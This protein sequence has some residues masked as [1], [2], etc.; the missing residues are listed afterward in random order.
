MMANHNQENSQQSDMAEKLIAVNR[1]ELF[2]DLK[3]VNG[4]G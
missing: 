4:C 2:S 1:A 3:A